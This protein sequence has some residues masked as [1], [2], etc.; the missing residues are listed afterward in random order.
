MQPSQDERVLT[1]LIVVR[2]LSRS[3]T[4]FRASVTQKR[5][6]QYELLLRYIFSLSNP[7]YGSDPDVYMTYNAD[8]Q[9]VSSQ[10]KYNNHRPGAEWASAR[11][12]CGENDVK[13]TTGSLRTSKAVSGGRGIQGVWTALE[14]LQY[15]TNV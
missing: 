9:C 7:L 3:S 4:S 15:F 2:L 10:T 12:V 8:V 5:V 6:S 13:R 14:R 1:C 11:F